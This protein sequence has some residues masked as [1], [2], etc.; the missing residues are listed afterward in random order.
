M[1]TQVRAAWRVLLGRQAADPTGPSCLRC[2]DHQARIQELRA[3]VTYWKAR[4]ERSTEALLMKS[5]GVV[6]VA[7]QAKPTSRNGVQ[8]A[9]SA[10]G[11]HTI[12]KPATDDSSE[13]GQGQMSGARRA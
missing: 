9:I 4:E 1:F 10:L 13:P 11:V 8:A 3:E 12:H 6:G 7:H 2:A 5:A